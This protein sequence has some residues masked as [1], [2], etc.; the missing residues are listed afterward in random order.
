MTQ[1]KRVHDITKY[2]TQ[3]KRVHDITNLSKIHHSSK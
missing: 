2:T 1:Y 3:Y